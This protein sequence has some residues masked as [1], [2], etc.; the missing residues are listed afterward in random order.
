MAPESVQKSQYSTKSDVYSFGVTIVEIL[1]RE[2]PFKRYNN[3]Q[4]I[5]D[6]LSDK[7]HPEKELTSEIYSE[8]IIELVGACTE[9][10][11]ELRPDFGQ[12]TKILNPE[13]FL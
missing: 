12:I 13:F 9:K 7:I 5:S 1:T 8:K 2:K 4:F 11:P 10:D 3:N 6:L